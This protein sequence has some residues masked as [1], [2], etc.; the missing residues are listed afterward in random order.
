M[1]VKMFKSTGKGG[2]YSPGMI[3]SIEKMNIY[4][5]VDES[6]TATSII[7]RA[8]LTLRIQV[9]R[10]TRLTNARSKKWENHESMMAIYFAWY[11]WCRKHETL[12]RATPAM[13]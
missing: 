3:T 9:R 2:R 4:G 1:I 11:N 5:N 13:A 6:R 7:E 10:M 12:K 8:N